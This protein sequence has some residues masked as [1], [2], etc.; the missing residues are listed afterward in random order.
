MATNELL[1]NSWWT[2]YRAA[3]VEIEL[4][5]LQARIEAARVAITQQMEQ[6]L[7]CNG[8]DGGERQKMLDALANLR[9][10]QK[11]ELRRSTENGDSH[12][13]MHGEATS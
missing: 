10:L 4:N 1:A 12:H 9:A 8:T 11:L 5:K 13:A 2:L 7:T 6:L 3:M